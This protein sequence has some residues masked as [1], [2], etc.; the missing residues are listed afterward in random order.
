MGEVPF[1]VHLGEHGS[2]KSAHAENGQVHGCTDGQNAPH[3]GLFPQ[4]GASFLQIKE[5]R[6]GER[7]E[8]RVERSGHSGQQGSRGSGARGAGTRSAVELNH[9]DV[10]RIGLT[11]VRGNARRGGAPRNSEYRAVL[12]PLREQAGRVTGHGLQPL[13]ARG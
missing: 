2:L 11:Q 8:L 12:D 10:L 1:R 7:I 6:G 3:G 9:R 4:Q 13:T 5:C